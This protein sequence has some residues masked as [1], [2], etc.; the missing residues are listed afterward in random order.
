MKITYKFGKDGEAKPTAKIGDA[1]TTPEGPGKIK[2]INAN[3]DT[4][5]VTLSSGDMA[6]FPSWQVKLKGAKK[7]G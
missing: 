5:T 2:H 6:A 1:V 7:N 4:V 3:S